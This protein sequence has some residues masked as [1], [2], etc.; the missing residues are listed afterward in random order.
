MSGNQAIALGAGVLAA[1]LVFVTAGAALGAYAG[2]AASIAFSAASLGATYLLGTPKQNSGQDAAAEELNIANSSSAYAVPV[3]FGTQRLAGNFL[4][5]DEDTF[6]SEEIKEEQDDAGGKG[7]GSGTDPTVTGYKYFL[8]FEYGL[9]MGPVDGVWQVLSDPGQNELLD[10]EDEEIILFDGEETLELDATAMGEDQGGTI[11]LYCGS[12]TQVRQPDSYSDDGMNYRNVCWAMFE[13]YHMGGAP[14]PNSYLFELTRWPRCYGVDGEI[15]ADLKVRGSADSGRLE[16]YDAN[17]AAILWEV[18]TNQVW[19]RGLAPAMLDQD[20]F[21]EASVFFENQN[22]GMSFPLTEQQSLSDIVESIRLHVDTILVWNGENV[23]CRVLM[24]PGQA[25]RDILRID[26]N[27]IRDLEVTRP[28][29][30]DTTN[31]V[32]C[33]FVCREDNYQ[34]ENVIIQNIGAIETVGM[35][36]SRKIGLRGFSTWDNADRSARRILAD[37]C[38]PAATIS[39]KID[40]YGSCIECGDLVELHWSEWS[41][42]PITSWWRVATVSDDQQD[43]AGISI[44]ALEEID[45]APQEGEPET[46]VQ[47]VPLWEQVTPVTAAEARLTA[48]VGEQPLL[49]FSPMRVFELPPLLAEWQATLCF[50][51]QRKTTAQQAAAIYWSPDGLADYGY[52]ASLG[53]WAVTGTLV[54]AM[55]TSAVDIDRGETGIVIQ[56]N[57]DSFDAATILGSANKVLSDADHM[58]VLIAKPQDLLL[59]D[60]EIFQVGKATA[61]G[62]GQYRLQNFI[63]ARY[64]TRQA[65]HSNGVAIAYVA[66]LSSSQYC[67]L[68]GNVPSLQNVDFRAYPVGIR[69]SGNTPTDFAG[70]NTPGGYLVGYGGLPEP[71]EL[72]DSTGPVPWVIRCR[73]R[74]PNVGNETF[75]VEMNRVLTS[76]GDL[77]YVYQTYSGS[78][79][80]QDPTPCS[81][82]FAPD[83]G[84]QFGG[85]ITI[86]IASTPF[87]IAPRIYGVLDGKLSTDWMQV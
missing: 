61:L 82:T 58:D 60:N 37:L 21:V 36:N 35:I 5:Y 3:I 80:R 38:Y 16:Y 49:E 48:P 4:R 57:Q 71:P 24:D 51:A 54:G 50:L 39:F 15:I 32:R 74:L 47:P 20:S 66:L 42:G 85:M 83:D 43:S 11:V 55:A 77:G 28:A 79:P 75:E 22:I 52:I 40:R 6:R 8:S 27:A 65:S 45:L 10:N 63:R 68:Q 25:Y 19:G 64:D 18:L 46:F 26:A 56:L 69:G 53:C 59:I 31:E 44:T 9:C 34:E 81:F 62:G 17:P 76:I 87:N 84:S 7:G 23:R 67:V 14:A 86:T 70:P 78:N 29:W 33:E 73:P 72:F 12:K 41:D 30:P 2:L 1:G 13:D